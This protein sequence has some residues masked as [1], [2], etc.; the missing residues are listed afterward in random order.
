MHTSASARRHADTR[1]RLHALVGVLLLIPLLLVLALALAAC[2]VRDKDAVNVTPQLVPAEL[3]VAPEGLDSNPGTPAAPLR[4]L[5]RAA[6][7]VTPGAIVNVLPGAYQGGFRTTVDG[8]PEARIVF[9]STR[10]WGARIVPPPAGAQPAGKMAWDNRASYVDIQGFEVDGSLAPG[11]A[12]A[13]WRIGIYSG[14]SHDRILGNHVH[15]IATTLPCDS[16][17]GS[18][19]GVDSYYHGKDSAVNGNSVHDIGPPGCRYVQ[20]IYFATTGSIRNNIVY[21]VAEAGIHL[22]HDAREVVI[23]NNTVT[24]SNTGILVGGGD[25]YHTQ[26][27]NDHTRVFNNIVFD[28]RHGI[29]EQGAT[30]PHNSYRNNLVFQN[31]AGDWQLAKGMSHSGTVTQA[32]RFLDYRRDGT[33]DFRLAAHS[34]AIGSGLDAESSASASAR[35]GADTG[36]D[37]PDFNGKPRAHA[38]AIDIG[39]CQH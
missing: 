20:G 23:A 8:L 24:A 25:F 22:W 7:L 11:E 35:P 21:R 3:F 27:P 15:D 38:A 28:N 19:I 6:Q 26:G 30:G 1:M 29:S 14:G 13:R 17:G 39:A 31:G 2:T 10:R 16:G 12:G 37:G 36:V 32:P 4:S 5:A 34:P 33:P 18:G 9:R